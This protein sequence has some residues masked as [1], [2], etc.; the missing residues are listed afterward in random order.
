MSGSP[1]TIKDQVRKGEAKEEGF[2]PAGRS[3]SMRLVKPNCNV[4]GL[5]W[6]NE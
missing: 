2:D 3:T 1:I 4:C 5:E 6:E